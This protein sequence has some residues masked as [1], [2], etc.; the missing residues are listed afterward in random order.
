MVGPS[1]IRLAHEILHTFDSAIVGDKEVAV[2]FE[3]NDHK[4]L[5]SL[6]H[7]WRNPGVARGHLPPKV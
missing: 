6:P 1:V 2:Q 7:R 3:Y 5:R 4:M